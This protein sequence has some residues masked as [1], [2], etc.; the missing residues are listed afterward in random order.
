MR[1]D[2]YSKSE[3]ATPPFRMPK[4]VVV[5]LRGFAMT[6]G[7]SSRAQRGDLSFSFKPKDKSEIATPLHLTYQVEKF[8]TI[9]KGG[10]SLLFLQQVLPAQPQNCRGIGSGD[11]FMLAL[12]PPPCFPARLHLGGSFVGIDPIRAQGRGHA[13]AMEES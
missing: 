10:E 1:G 6:K 8:F 12:T 2:N 11:I 13:H 4:L 9:K 5:K 7:L 3:I